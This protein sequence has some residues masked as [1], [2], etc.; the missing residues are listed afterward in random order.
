M[1]MMFSTIVFGV[2]DECQIRMT[3]HV[4][5]FREAEK[6]SRRHTQPDEYTY[7]INIILQTAYNTMAKNPH[8]RIL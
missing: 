1:A 2:D 3:K 7:G 5:I 4:R 8:C 6:L